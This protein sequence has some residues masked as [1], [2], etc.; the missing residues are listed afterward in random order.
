MPNHALISNPGGI[1]ALMMD[2]FGS[3]G[4]PVGLVTAGARILPDCTST[5]TV[6]RVGKANATWFYIR[7]ATIS[8]PPRYGTWTVS[9]PANCLN[10]S[11]PKWAWPSLPP[12]AKF[13]LLGLAFASAT[14]SRTV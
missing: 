3:L 4:L 7:E 8:V 5:N 6:M 1:A 12:N 10:V 11:P 13:K 14:S 9:R 2:T